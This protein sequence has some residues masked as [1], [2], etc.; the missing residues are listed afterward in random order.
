MAILIIVSIILI[1]LYIVRISNNQDLIKENCK[2]EIMT[3]NIKHAKNHFYKTKLSTSLLIFTIVFTIIVLICDFTSLEAIIIDYFAY[4][5]YTEEETSKVLYFIP[6]FTFC[7]RGIINEVNLGDFLLKYFNVKEPELEE[8]LL[9]SLLYKKKPSTDTQKTELPI[10]NSKP[11]L[12]VPNPGEI[13]DNQ[14]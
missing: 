14:K 8:N 10:D 5:F 2:T 13:K 7:I 1:L 11:T 12:E 3:A 4:D 9:K 6:I